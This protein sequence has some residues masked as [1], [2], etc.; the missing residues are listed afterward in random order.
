MSIIQLEAKSRDIK[1]ES[2]KENIIP[3]VVY[4]PDTKNQNLKLDYKNFIKAYQEAGESSL[5][6]LIVDNKSP[7]KVLI[8]DIQKDPVSDKYIHIDFY[9]LNMN[10]KLNVEVGLVFKGIEE[11]EKAT[12]GE[13]IR[14]M[15][16]LEIE[17]LPK[18]LIKEIEVNLVEFLK[19]IGDVIYAKDIKLPEGLSLVTNNENTV[20]SAQEIKEEI[21]EEPKEEV[22]EGE[23]GEEKE[24]DEKEA[25]EKE[26]GEEKEQT[27]TEDKSGETGNK[28][29]EG[30]K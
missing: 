4:G 13:V 5:L 26:G 18:D 14:T 28:Q 3:A 19:N 10:K 1:D 17:C 16:K 24:G 7:V 25:E 9:Q 8:H 2:R 30:K 27:K 15:D 11:V 21:I 20:A 12:A 22:A 29:E 23:E 6:D